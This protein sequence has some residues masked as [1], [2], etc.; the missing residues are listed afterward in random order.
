MLKEIRIWWRLR[1]TLQRIREL[2]TMTWNIQKGISITLVILQGITQV[3]E[4]VPDKYKHW[5]FGAHLLTELI[6]K[7]QAQFKNPDATPAQVPW[8]PDK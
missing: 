1:Q 6:L 4:F 7:W 3:S 2:S 5:A 8:Q